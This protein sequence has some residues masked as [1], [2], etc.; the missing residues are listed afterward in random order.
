MNNRPIH[1]MG[2]LAMI[3]TCISIGS[4]RGQTQAHYW[5]NGQ[6]KSEGDT[7]NGQMTG[8][9]TNWRENGSKLSEG[10][11]L[12]GNQAG[13]WTYYYTNGEKWSEVSIDS[14]MST[15]WYMNGNKE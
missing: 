12:E 8:T 11:Y 13:T 1:I 5:P 7:L 6:K 4:V 9:W 3:W 15:A 10:E 2:L 14:G